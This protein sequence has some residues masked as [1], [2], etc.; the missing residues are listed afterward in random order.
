MIGGRKKSTIDQTTLK[1]QQGMPHNT[2]K[3]L[4]NIETLLQIMVFLLAKIGQN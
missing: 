2:K 4:S 3:P 1:K